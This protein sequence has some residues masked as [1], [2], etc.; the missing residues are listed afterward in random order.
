MKKELSAGEVKKL[1]EQTGAGMMEA[2]KALLEAGGDIPKAIEVLRKKGMM[3]AQAKAERSTKQGIVE[4]YIHGEGRIG[5]LLEVNCETDFVARNQDFRNLVHDLVLHVAASSPLFIS[6][7]DVPAAVVEKEKEIYSAA[8]V[9]E[10]KV[11]NIVEKIVAGRVEKFFEE[12]CLLEQPFVKDPDISVQDLITQKVAVIGENI[13]VRRFT[14]YV[15][16]E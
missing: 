12:V 5:I 16:G 9:A 3:K 1:R 11:G 6:R 8:A 7:T 2:K 4:S 10:G 15:L 13:Q 14:R